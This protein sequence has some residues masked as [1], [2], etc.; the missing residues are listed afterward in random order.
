MLSHCQGRVFLMMSSHTYWARFSLVLCI[1]VALAV[2]KVVTL[3]GS[4]RNSHHS[5]KLYYS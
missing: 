2:D 4:A 3:L 5:T 1:V